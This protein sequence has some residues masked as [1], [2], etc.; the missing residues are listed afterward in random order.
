MLWQF[1]LRKGS[2]YVPTTAQTE[3][4]FYLD[5]EPVEVAAVQDLEAVQRAIVGAMNRGNPRVPTPTRATS[6]KPVVLKYS[7]V[8]SWSRFER[9]AENWTL[10]DGNGGYQLVPG[11]RR[12]DR[13]WED[14][15]DKKEEFPADIGI[16]G[17]ARQVA[18][19]IRSVFDNLANR[20]GSTSE[21]K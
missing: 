21:P 11:R 20:G 1:Y 17:V 14:D 7:D 16:E 10:A 15:L 19:S 9:D 12:A 3:A 5:I 2:V 18:R 13:G 4:G 8:K 6:P